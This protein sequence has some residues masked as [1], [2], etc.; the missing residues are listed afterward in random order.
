MRKISPFILALVTSSAAL[1]ALAGH[2]HDDGYF[3]EA[4]VISA[5]PQVERVNE[6]RQECRTDYVR[7]NYS[8]REDRSPAGSII[9]GIAGGLLGS[10]IGRGNGRVAAAA[11]GAGV[12]AVVGDR[13]SSNGRDNY[14]VRERPVESCVTVDNWRTVDRG[15]LVTYRYN[16]RD[17][18]TVTN[19]HPGNS[20]RV[21][22]D[23]EPADGVVVSQQFGAAP[24]QI[25]YSEPNHGHGKHHR[26]RQYW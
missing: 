19:Q 20:I 18:T 5:V 13:M 3:D 16:G 8:Y 7:E 26:N 15:Y 1:P 22:V 10:T 2:G 12:G 14:G 24:R 17:Y 4:R 9:G 11:V 6:P 23:V 21:R 25:S